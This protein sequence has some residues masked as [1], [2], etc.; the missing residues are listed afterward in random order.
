[1]NVHPDR[2]DFRPLNELPAA[3]QRNAELSYKD[4]FRF[5]LRRGRTIL[6]VGGVAGLAVLAI[7]MLQQP[8]YTAKSL[9][10]ITAPQTRIGEVDQTSNNP[11]PDSGL[12]DSQIEILHSR[13]LSRMVADQLKLIEDPAWNS[14]LRQS[15]LAHSIKTALLSPYSGDPQ[16]A[17]ASA[18]RSAREHVISMVQNSVSAKRRGLTYVIEVSATANNPVQAARLA[19]SLVDQYFQNDL[20][21]RFDSAEKSNQWLSERIA[22]LRTQVEQ[23]ESA[24]EDYR[25]KNGLLTASGASLTEQQMTG[26][27]GM[28]M[29]ARADLAEKEARYRQLQSLRASGGEVDSLS[30]A[31]VSTTITELRT[32]QADVD[33]REA[34]MTRKYGYRHPSLEAVRVEK[35]RID[36][37]IQAEVARIARNLED[38]VDVARSRLQSLQ[39]TASGVEGKLASNNEGGVKLRELERD[40]AATRMIYENFLKRSQEISEAKT[41]TE[42]DAKVVSEASAP[43][44]PSSPNLPSAAFIALIAAVVFGAGA[45][46][47]I[48]MFDEGLEGLED[49]QRETGKPC[50]GSLPVLRKGSLN[51]LPSNERHPAGFLLDKPISAFA[52]GVRLL[53]ASLLFSE[54]GPEPKVIAVTSA[55]AGEGKTTASFCL[56][57]IAALAGQRVIVVDCDL[58][59][60]SFN[61]LLKFQPTKGIIHVLTRRVQW[62]DVITKDDKTGFH[63]LPAEATGFTSMDVFGGAQMRELLAD[64]SS[65]YDLIIL[66]CPP[67]LAVAEARMVARVADKTL[68][69]TRWTKTS[70]RSVRIA[71]ENLENSGAH[72]AGVALNCVNPQALGRGESAT[73]GY[74]NAYASGYYAA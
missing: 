47:L 3:P 24:V 59:H 6:F 5:L 25:T 20:Q 66:D 74:K 54:T 55:L 69:V 15:S 57:R 43:T 38:E 36:E 64:L 12:I 7:A 65:N 2:Q 49:T 50:I 48:E 23:K 13:R 61:S 72:V 67:V 35:A 39:G 8:K 11:I 9:I 62:R 33:A 68:V 28:V 58:R 27:Q 60:R 10:M 1:M 19:N 44:A 37:Q 26:M 17:G 30:S 18:Q 71:I 45:G 42:S 46:L 32:K 4:L 29:A 14:S 40:A 31:L 41:M 22:Q 73:P 21:T 70:K 56:A 16:T 52:E 34:D 51:R 63:L 53:R